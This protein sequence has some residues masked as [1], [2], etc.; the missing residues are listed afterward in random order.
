LSRLPR[1]WIR[2]A[3]VAACL[4][5]G[6]QVWNYAQYG[7]QLIRPVQVQRTVEYQV[8]EWLER[9]GPYARVFVPG[10]M[11]LWLNDFTD[12]PQLAGCCDQSPPNFETR[13]AEYTIYSDSHAGDLAAYYSLIWLKAF[14]VQAIA[15]DG[16][17]ST[18][19]YHP[20]AHPRK[21]DGMLRQLWKQGDNEILEVPHRTSGLAHVIPEDALA[22]RT[23][24]H[25]L[26]V[27]PL[28]PYI[29]A[30]DDPALP[31]AAMD[32]RNQHDATIRARLS[33]GEAISV[34]VTYTKGWHATVNGRPREVSRDAIG[35]LAIRPRCE[36]DCVIR[37]TYDGGTEMLAARIA[38]WS[39]T[40]LLFGGVVLAERK[41]RGVAGMQA[42]P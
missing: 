28:L 25:G 2:V 12:T 42:V 22:R 13:V 18:E 10:S 30:L 5:A 34:Q 35:L 20:Y 7:R 1:F 38:S 39:M 24:I 15:M 11:S 41:R 37:L 9:N 32:W 3:A 19:A 23:P 27:A 4:L 6:M 31:S 14:G 16:A 17:A 36:G 40:V 26:D 8:A 29:A 21:F 33:E